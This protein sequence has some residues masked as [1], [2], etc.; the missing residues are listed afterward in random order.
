MKVGLLFGSFNPVHTGHLII[1][2]HVKNYYT[3]KIWFVVS[4]QNPFKKNSELL[5]V[6]SRISLAKAAIINN[7]K[8]EVSDAEV[9][10]PLPSYTID[11]LLHL[12]NIY[13][14]HEFFLIMGSDNFLRIPKWKSSDVLLHDYK[15]FVYERP[16][17]KLD[18]NIS[19]SNVKILD[20]PF[21]NISSTEIRKLIKAKK[22]IRYIVPEAVLTMIKNHKFYL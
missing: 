15:I 8:F 1:S 12:K 18:S 2:E 21:I 17:F 13:P 6:Q 5:D 9:N 10:L 4:P 7:E 16:G 11:T 20:A 3:D 19:D 22:S 14:E